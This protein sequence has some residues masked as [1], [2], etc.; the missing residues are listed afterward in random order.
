VAR[1]EPASGYGGKRVAYFDEILFIPA[2]D[3][4]S[5]QAGVETGAYHFVHQV[6]LFG[7]GLRD[8]LDP[9]LRGV[10]GATRET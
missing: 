4:A 2:P 10:T 3:V 9:R 1:P 6:N 8:L 7:D 5:R